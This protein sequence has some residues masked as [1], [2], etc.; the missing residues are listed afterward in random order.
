MNYICQYCGKVCKNKN[1]LVQHERLC[2]LNP[3]HQEHTGF[4]YG[5]SKGLNKN[6]NKTLKKISEKLLLK[7]YKEFIPY[8]CE[9]CGKL[10]KENYGS[11]RFC[12]R[13]CANSKQHTNEQKEKI[14]NSII[15]HYRSI[16]RHISSDEKICPICGKKYYTNNKTCSKECGYK[17]KTQ[18]GV[19]EETRQKLSDRVQQKI[20]NG[21]HIGWTTR[22][23]E[24]YPEKF[25]KRVLE[26]NDIKYEFNKPILKN[27][28][29][30]YE[31][32]CYF[33]DF[34]LSNKIDLEIDGKQHKIKERKTH[35]KIRDERL[36]NNGWKVYR[37]E[38]KNPNTK[39]NS[40]YI[41]EEINK[42]LKWYNEN[43]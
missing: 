18:N 13:K 9:K 14:K 21:I 39:K 7:N 40:D 3:N 35:D 27:N 6:N 42:F 37:I 31:N 41:K 2:K 11:G 19:S 8:Q 43:K 10:V 5:W 34:A 1:S 17:Y 28:L 12:S 24:S 22:N 30:V 23:I 36:I 29:G 38:W 33:L 20:K 25:F 26:N 15:N 32:G 16:Q 4:Q